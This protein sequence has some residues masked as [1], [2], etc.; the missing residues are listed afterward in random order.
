MGYFVNDNSFE[1]TKKLIRKTFFPVLIISLKYFPI[2][3]LLVFKFLPSFLWVPFF[4]L[5]SLFF[6]IY[7]NITTKK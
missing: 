6:G 1:E 4:N 3:Q 7:V 2:I 5:L